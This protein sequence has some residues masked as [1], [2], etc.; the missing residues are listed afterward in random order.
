MTDSR[1]DL[2]LLEADETRE[3]E[4]VDHSIQGRGLQD[5]KTEMSEK[6][7]ETRNGANRS[8]GS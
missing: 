3:A 5:R 7:R 6:A 2:G 8:F 4:N 1:D